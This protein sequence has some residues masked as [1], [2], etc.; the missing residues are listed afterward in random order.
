[1]SVSFQ[2]TELRMDPIL[3]I[4]ISISI[5]CLL[6]IHANSIVMKTKHPALISQV[7][8]VFPGFYFAGLEDK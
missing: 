3:V 6:I 2:E 1:M 8:L 7:G 5:P 4:Y